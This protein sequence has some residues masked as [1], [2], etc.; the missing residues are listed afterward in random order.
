MADQE[1]RAALVRHWDAS[2]S[3]DPETEHEIYDD[4]VLCEYPQ[5]GERIHGNHK[6][7]G[8]TIPGSLPASTSVAW[9]VWKI[10]G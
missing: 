2:A 7:C 8:D 4:N 1:K 10:Y 9:W 3:G 6:P 5:S